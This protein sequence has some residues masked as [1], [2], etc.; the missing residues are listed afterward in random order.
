MGR[1]LEAYS[2]A[3]TGDAITSLAKLRPR[4]AR[5]LQ[6]MDQIMQEIDCVLT[7]LI[8]VD[9][10]ECNDTIKV[11]P[12]ESPLADGLVVHG[13]SDFNE[14]SLTG[15]S[16]PIAKSVGEAVYVGTINSSKPLFVHVTEISGTSMLDQI[17]K[18][19]KDGQAK[20]API[21]RFADRLTSHFV[22]LI[23]A[24]GSA[25]WV[26]WLALGL[27]GSL[28]PTY[29]DTQVG[30]WPLWSVQFAIA[31]FVIACPC[32]IGLAA[33]TAL[34]VGGGLA[35]QNG[36]L[37]QGGGVAFQEASVLDRVAFDKTGTLTEGGSPTVTGHKISI[38]HEMSR[39]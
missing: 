27:S 25:T 26:I 34:F 32:G 4:V 6:S 11:L 24:I 29:R 8:D 12:G 18:V 19:V 9:L 20:R 30:G 39:S 37:V 33:R 21:E 23:V 7:Q 36:I 22:P 17:M 5:L 13:C 35:A 15:E 28:P 2:K 10:L 16:K 14:S 38:D 31:L 3:K 1:F